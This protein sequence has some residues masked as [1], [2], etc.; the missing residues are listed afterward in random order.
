V[1]ARPAWLFAAVCF[2]FLAACAGPEDRLPPPPTQEIAPT[3]KLRVGIGLGA[4]S[5]AFWTT[6]DAATGRPKGVTVELGADIA[7]R[8]G[9]PLELVV[10]NN[11]GEVTA[12]GPRGEWDVAFVPVD[13][14]RRKMVDFG[15]PYVLL[16]STYLVPA[17]STARAIEDVDRAGTRVIGIENTTTARSA[18]RSLKNT[19]VKTFK[20]IDDIYAAMRAGEADA[21]ALGR[22]S[23]DSLAASFPGSRVLPGHYQATGVAVAVPKNHPAALAY[24][25]AWIEQAKSTGAVRRA[26]DNAGMKDAQVAPAGALQ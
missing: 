24:V 15:P 4:V 11:S 5:S 18:A 1:S 25:S 23:L 2:A 3:G 8:L 17:G 22:E 16:E 12:A 13:A 26:L 6:R 19:T 21:V 14:E 7:S 20:T 9:V 10:Y